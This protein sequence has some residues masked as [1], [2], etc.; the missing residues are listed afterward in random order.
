MDK[1]QH[2]EAIRK[3]VAAEK[4][5]G[6]FLVGLAQR[7][8]VLERDLPALIGASQAS[9]HKYRRNQSPC[10]IY[11]RDAANKL[12]AAKGLP[13][14]TGNG[15]ATI[16]KPPRGMRV[17]QVPSGFLEGLEGQLGIQTKELLGLLGVASGQYHIWKKR[18]HCPIWVRS[19]VSGLMAERKIIDG[20]LTDKPPRAVRV[21]HANGNV[22]TIIPQTYRQP[23]TGG[24]GVVLIHVMVPL[25]QVPV[26]SAMLSG[27]GFPIQVGS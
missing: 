27:L 14:V 11:I 3:A 26:V 10:P 6:G 13:T 22:P 23:P 19:A 15:A 5:D 2:I 17:E 9:I 18:G 12:L 7:L 1:A 8:G 24:N 4:V 16:E 21:K 20:E 25:H